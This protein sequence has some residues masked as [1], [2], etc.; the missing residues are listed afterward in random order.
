MPS[1]T[2][3]LDPPVIGDASVFLREEKEEGLHPVS[4]SPQRR[5]DSWARIARQLMRVASLRI[6]HVPPVAVIVVEF[7]QVV[8]TQL[9]GKGEE[10]AHH[11]DP[12]RE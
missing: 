8:C 12:G 2:S 7:T 3:T 10:I 6:N 4:I 9:A 5:R 11:K 1:L